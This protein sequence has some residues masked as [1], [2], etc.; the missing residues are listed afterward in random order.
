MALT[1]GFRKS[2]VTKTILAPHLSTT[3][4]PLARNVLRPGGPRSWARR[5]RP[6]FRGIN[7]I[8]I[9]YSMGI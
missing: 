4:A 7:Q 3:H 8:V 6:R 2:G 9:E 1:V 5:R